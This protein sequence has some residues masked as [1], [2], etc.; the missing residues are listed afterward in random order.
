MRGDQETADM[1]ELRRQIFG[2]S[3][4]QVFLLRIVANV[5]EGQHRD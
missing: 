2:D 4:G 1:G 3:V 5:A